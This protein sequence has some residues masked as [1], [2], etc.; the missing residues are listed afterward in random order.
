VKTD[1]SERFTEYWGQK[2]RMG[3]MMGEQILGQLLKARMKNW[4]KKA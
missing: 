1:G 3:L 4:I 2:G